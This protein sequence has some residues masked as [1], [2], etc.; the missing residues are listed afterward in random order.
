MTAESLDDIGQTVIDRIGVPKDRWEITAQLEV[1]GLRDSDARPRRTSSAAA[2]RCF[3][4]SATT[5]T[6]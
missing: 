5:S 4:S 2:A 3:A 6:A 1:L